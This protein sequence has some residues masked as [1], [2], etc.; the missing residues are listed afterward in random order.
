M[1]ND[2]LL[3]MVLYPLLDMR[4]WASLCKPLETPIANHSKRL[5]VNIEKTEA[6]VF[7]RTTPVSLVLTYQGQQIE[8]VPEFRYLGLDVHQSKGFPLCTYHLLA[9]A[10]KALFGLKQ[11]CM[12]LHITD[13]RLQCS[14]FN[15]LVRPILSYGCEVWA[16]EADHKDLKQIEGLHIE[17]LRSIL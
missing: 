2:S 11:R 16:V 12:E 13:A 4:E 5:T 14:L 7:S 8:Q 3:K 6:T 10:R 17:F 15:T 9:A 1:G